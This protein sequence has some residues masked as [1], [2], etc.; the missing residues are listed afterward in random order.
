[1]R[2]ST[3]A[4]ALAAAVPL[5]FAQTS[6]DC[7][8]TEKT[9]SADSGLSSSSYSA[10]FTQGSSANA[11]WSAAAYTD[12]TYGSDG[13][14]FS[15][16]NK[17]QAPTIQTDFYIFFGRI[18][19]V[20]KA[21]PGTGIVSSIVLESDDLDEIDWEFLGGSNGQ[22][23]SD[24]F[25]KGNTTA[26][27]RA[28]Y[29]DV[30][31]TQGTWHTYSVDWTKERI[32]WLID[33]TVVRTLAYDDSLTV[34]GTNYPQTPMRLKLGNWCG[35]C[36]SSSGTVEW[37]GGATTWDSAPYKMYVKKVE[38]TNNNPACEYTYGDKTGDYD[39]IKI[40]SSSGCSSSST[41]SSTGSTKTSSQTVVDISEQT[42]VVAS[43]TI[44]GSAYSTNSASIS[45]V[46]GD[47]TGAATTSTQAAG[48]NGTIS[49][50]AS[51]P[52]STSTVASSTG[53]AAFTSIMAGGALLSF[54]L[55]VFLL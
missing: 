52:S 25:G 34:G 5:A 35:G 36:S 12:I 42:G 39:S 51:G 10:D 16:A 48:G 17:N 46:N 22:V 11:S 53:A 54:A 37:A 3:T 38:I 15:I 29:H 4:A 13:A 45:A 41:G 40:S 6:T 28:E 33:G 32:E 1:M 20:M 44:T 2:F 31:D 26:Y 49:A 21:A 43:T 18:D 7:N 8:P 47:S 9:C 24:F 27:D 14:V 23:Q 55:A 30:S 50:T 19:I